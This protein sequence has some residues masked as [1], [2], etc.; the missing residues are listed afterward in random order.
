MNPSGHIFD[1]S[2]GLKKKLALAV[3]SD[4]PIFRLEAGQHRLEAISRLSVQQHHKEWPAQLYVD[5]FSPAVLTY[6][7]EN[8]KDIRIEDEESDALCQLSAFFRSGD[9]LETLGIDEKYFVNMK[10]SKLSDKVQTTLKKPYF[11]ENLKALIGEYPSVGT[12]FGNG[13]AAILNDSI[14]PLVRTFLAQNAQLVLTLQYID[15][16]LKS[17]RSSLNILFKDPTC[18]HLIGPNEFRWLNKFSTKNRTW[19]AGNPA[20]AADEFRKEGRFRVY[21]NNSVKERNVT[22]EQWTRRFE[23]LFD[24]LQKL[25][26]ADYTMALLFVPQ[27]ILGL[28]TNLHF[29]F[30]VSCENC[31]TIFLT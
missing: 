21:F 20:E 25:S 12:G 30:G 28:A 2:P 9:P 6:I 1:L 5:D 22:P 18:R 7:R 4:K 13:N 26:K 29:L 11:G 31:A 24:S 17:I 10:M 14:H 23:K 16:A 3:N 15:L 19:F 8:Q 27:G